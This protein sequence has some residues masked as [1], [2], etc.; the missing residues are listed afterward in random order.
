MSLCPRWKRY[1]YTVNTL[2]RYEEFD[3]TLGNPIIDCNNTD[4]KDNLN[5]KCDKDEYLWDC[6]S[7]NS[8]DKNILH[9][10]NRSVSN[11]KCYNDTL[12]EIVDECYETFSNR[13]K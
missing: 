5:C 10:G 1:Q 12:D 8:T 4:Q 3:I 11:T 9:K 13:F 7:I 6:I 2:K